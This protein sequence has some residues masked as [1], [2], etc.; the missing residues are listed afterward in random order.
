MVHPPS[1]LPICLQAIGAVSSLCLTAL[2]GALSVINYQTLYLVRSQQAKVARVAEIEKRLRD[3]GVPEK[4]T[5]IDRQQQ[6]IIELLEMTTGVPREEIA[7][8]GPAEQAKKAPNP[9]E[10]RP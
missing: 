1:R 6:R 7:V 5:A 8:P 3:G 2:V 10:T 9:E 4:V